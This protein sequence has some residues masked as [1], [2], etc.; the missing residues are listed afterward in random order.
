MKKLFQSNGGLLVLIALLLAAI[1]LVLSL[2]LSGA[3][4]LANL[5]GVVTTPFRAV[6]TAAADWAERS[7]SHRYREE[8]LA[9]EVERLRQEL[10]A[11]ERQVRE[12]E[13]AQEENQ[14]LRTLLELRQRR[15]DLTDLES[16]TVTA[17]AL[18]N[19]ESSFTISKGSNYG[20]QEGQ[21]VIDA[22]GNLVGVVREVGLNW[23]TVLTVVDTDID[24]GGK[25]SRPGEQISAVLEG[26]FAL[27]TQG[28]VKL[29]YLPEDIQLRSG[30]LVLTSG[31]GG[32]Y[33]PDLVVGT[34]ESVENDPSGM[35]RYAVVAPRAEL[36][37]LNQV[38]V[39][40]SFDIVE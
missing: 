4:P 2:I 8:V 28:R 34:V 21:C 22:Y 10:A 27:M 18:S 31:R 40:K 6:G 19:W 24:M 12:G 11:A 14:R 39:V 5:W 23:A 9:D 1:T 20:I 3:D 36:D 25:V 32:V 16:A 15:S 35:T 30:D 38:F 17:R 13:A 37:T 33:P 29:S 7:F 26:D